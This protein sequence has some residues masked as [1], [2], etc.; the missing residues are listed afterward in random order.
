SKFPGEVVLVNDGP[1][2]QLTTQMH[3]VAAGAVEP[4]AVPLSIDTL[5][6]WTPARL[7]QGKA[8][9]IGAERPRV[10]LEDGRELDD[11]RPAVAPGGTS[12]PA[13]TTRPSGTGKSAGPHCASS[14][15]AAA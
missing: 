9:A 1:H 15:W 7:V 6:R 13:C 8:T 3:R 14:S 5:L 4:A 2:H 11:D 12:P 10:R